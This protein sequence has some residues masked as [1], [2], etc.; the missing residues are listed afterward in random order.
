MKNSIPLLQ[1][2]IRLGLAAIAALPALASSHREAPLITSTPKIDC[3][4]FYAFNSYETGRTN[5]VTLVANYI[6]LQ[7]AYGGPNYFQLDTNALYEIHVDN[8]GDA[9]EDLTFQFR[10]QNTPRNLSLEIGSGSSKRTNSV[11]VLAIGQI[12]AGNTASLN[13]DQTYTLSVIQGLRRSGTATP[14]TNSVS[15]VFTKPQDY[16]GTKTFPDYNAYADQYIYSINLPGTTNKAKIFVAQRKDPF[17]VN[18]GETFDL[19]NISTSPLGPEDANRDSLADKNVTSIMLEIPKEFLRGAGVN[20]GI[21]GAWSTAS[22]IQN[23][24]TNQMS[25]LGMPLVNELV[26][27]LADKDKFNTSEPKDDLANFADYVTHPTLPA[28]IE[29]LFGG[30]GAVAPT[31]FPR[32]DL[33]AA[34]VTGVTGLNANGGAGEMQRLNMDILAVAAASQNRLGVIAGDNAGFPN[35]RRPGDDVVDIELRVAMGKLISLG[36]FGTVGQAPA[37]NAAFTDGAMVNA[38]FFLSRFPYLQ[39]PIPGSP[40]SAQFTVT[41]QTSG[42]VNGPFVNSFGAYDPST[43]TLKVTKPAPNTGFLRLK[44]ASPVTMENPAATSTNLSVK[45]K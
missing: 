45:I 8:T 15:G 35:G 22:L 21:I 2:S 20:G 16:V 26:I 29:L 27:G 4:D 33:V 3:A 5:Y 10:F 41:A 9:R 24:Q 39:T 19:I 11:P 7:D 14:L 13:V 34:F 43:R 6:P 42:N 38:S 23:G 44:S 25:R 31:L 30:A 37:G 1:A 28:I 40:N 32:T 36:L 12:T 18:L 17:V